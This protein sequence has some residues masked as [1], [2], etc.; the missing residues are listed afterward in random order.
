[1]ILAKLK[2]LRID[3]CDGSNTISNR[4]FYSQAFGFIDFATVFEN[5]FT[6]LENGYAHL[7]FEITGFFVSY[8]EI[9]QFSKKTDPFWSF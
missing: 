2:V 9:K 3:R 7:F 5:Y 6:Q 8:H 4:T 1:M